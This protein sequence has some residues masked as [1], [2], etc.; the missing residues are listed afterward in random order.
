MSDRILILG[1]TGFIGSAVVARL[2]AGDWA[3]PVVAGRSAKASLRLDATDAGQIAAA[4]KNCDALVNCVAGSTQTFRANAAALA[5]ALREAP[6]SLRVVHLSSMA[7]YG[8]AT[9]LVSEE[10][11]PRADLGE[12]SSAKLEAEHLIRKA[13][14]QT[15]LLRPGIVYGGGSPQW[16]QRIAQLLR[17]HRLGDL[18]AAGDGCCNLVHVR[19]VATA[20]ESALRTDAARGGTFN[21]SLPE[22][23]TWNEYLVRF[24][25]A[26]GAVP[27]RR[28]AGWRLRLEG[29]LLAPPL[30]IMEILAGRLRM[31]AGRLPPPIPNS[32]LRLFQQD[33]RLD[34]GAAERV[35]GMRWTPLE[36][37]LAEAARSLG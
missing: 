3:Q 7:V 8:L 34:P 16:T 5:A 9:G 32:L 12:Y 35:M 29:R 22:P 23:P 27:V 17:E 37:G 2:R 31:P 24:A 19:D 4:L 6:A 26:L 10:T 11:E 20:V 13:A 28:V 14:S 36:D 33:I 21:L 18:G 25:L 1:G 30:K 15:V